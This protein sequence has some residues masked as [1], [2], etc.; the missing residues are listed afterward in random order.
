MQ[1]DAEHGVDRA[2]RQ[3]FGGTGEVAG[4]VVHQHVDPAVVRPDRLHHCLDRLGIAH[5]AHDGQDLAA[6]GGH[7]LVRRLAQHRLP[8]ARDRQLRAELQEALAHGPAQP[9]AAAGDQ[10]HLVFEQIRQKHDLL[11]SRLTEERTSPSREKFPVMYRRYR[12][13][14]KTLRHANAQ[15][16]A[17]GADLPLG[18]ELDIQQHSSHPRVAGLDLASPAAQLEHGA[19]RRRA[20][21][22]DLQRGGHEADGRLGARLPAFSLV[23]GDRGRPRAVA[24]D[25]RRDQAAINV[26]GDG[27]V[28]GPRHE[29]AD[30][31]VAVG[32]AL[33]L[34]PLVV[35]PAAAVA[36]GRRSQ[37]TGP[38]LR[39]R[40]SF[41][42]TGPS[43]PAPLSGIR[44]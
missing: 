5:V 21:E 18:A 43:A 25:Q 26:A 16:L 37:G 19:E 33:D 32:V 13:F 30:G 10:D 42:V 4:G 38:G 14:P 31:L 39:S 24:V 22:I 41:G 9:G 12:S 6:A 7:H 23:R 44:S 2:R 29:V 15:D 17:A 27:H 35:Q 20:Q 36:V 8:A 3:P 40:W 1:H 28:I 11:L 34:Q